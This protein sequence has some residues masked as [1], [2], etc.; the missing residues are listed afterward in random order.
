MDISK[1]K[2]EQSAGENSSQYQLVGDNSSQT[3]IETQVN[4][5][6]NTSITYNGM[7]PTDVVQFTTTLSAQVT[8]QALSLCTEVAEET[9]IK[10]I[11]SFETI[12]IPRITQ[13]E[14]VV[15]HLTDPKFQF[16]IRDAQIRIRL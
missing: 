12:W 7:T 16:M 2:Q 15:Y 14:D 1:T 5:V 9:A 3:I 10:K 8:K 6:N 11:Q 13:M 4:S